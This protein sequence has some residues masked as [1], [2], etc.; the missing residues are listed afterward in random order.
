MTST[1]IGGQIF[2]LLYSVLL[3]GSCP[4]EVGGHHRNCRVAR[5][6]ARRLDKG[7]IDAKAF[8]FKAIK[9]PRS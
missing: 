4:M 5:G 8:V 9:Q 7:S 3:C 2:E 1:L 6:N